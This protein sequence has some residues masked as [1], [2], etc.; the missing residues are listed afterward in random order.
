MSRRGRNKSAFSL[1][2]FQDIIMSVTGIMILITLILSLEMMERQE[3]SPRERTSEI[4]SQLKAAVGEV[5]DLVQAHAR[6]PC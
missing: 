1:F 3:E 4:I 5:E 2:V 6:T